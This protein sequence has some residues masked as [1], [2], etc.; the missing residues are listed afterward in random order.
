MSV[1]DDDRIVFRLTGAEAQHGLAFANLA[2]FLEYFRS[3]LRDFDRQRRAEKTKRGGH[4]TTREDLVTGFR[5]VTF[6]PGSAVMEVEPIAQEDEQDRVADTEKL[7]VENLRAFIDTIE[8]PDE[9]LDPAVTDAV[10]MARRQLG[11]DGKIEITVG[12]K[13]RP[14]R[15]TI[16]DRER[17]A[18]LEQRVKRVQVKDMRI[19]GRLHMIDVEPEKV[20]IRAADGVD[21]VCSY[22]SNLEEAVSALVRQRVWARGL[23]VQLTA[24]RGRLSLTEIH[25][26]ERHEQ[27]PL[28]TFERVPMAELLSRQG[29]TSPQGLPSLL[30]DIAVDDEEADAFL[31]AIL[32]EG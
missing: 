13:R 29:I 7:A 1:R 31:D 4:P 25:P 2:A 14:V 27:T 28:F 30:G 23:G 5:L 19:S 16:I 9:I 24:N 18:A 26:I 3:A 10:E 11:E 21:W 32:D 22:P 8:S 12:P 17:V 15:H 6:K 20:G